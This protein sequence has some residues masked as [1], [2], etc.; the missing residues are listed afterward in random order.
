MSNYPNVEVHPSGKFIG[1]IGLEGVKIVSTG[2]TELFCKLKDLRS[3]N[4]RCCAFSP[5]GKYYA[6]VLSANHS[7]ELHL[8]RVDKLTTLRDTSVDLCKLFPNFKFTRMYNEHLQCKWSPDSELIA[9]CSNT[10]CLLLLDKNLEKVTDVVEDILPEDRFPSWSG[11]FDFA[12][13]SRHDLL[14]VGTSHGQLYVVSTESKRIVLET[15]TFTK[16]AIDCIKY[17]PQGTQI[18]VSTRDMCVYLI[19]SYTGYISFTIDIKSQ[20]TGIEDRL[21]SFPA[22]MSLDFST[23]GDYL[24]TGS[25]D[26]MIRLWKLF[27]P[28]ISLLRLCTMALLSYTA[29]SDVKDLPLPHQLRDLLLSFPK[30]K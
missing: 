14:A 15:E 10:F 12:P 19:D 6:I 23:K 16:E 20:C 8:S 21:E 7:F 25:C 4:Y 22:I 3:C 30:Y 26:G 24:V 1:Y 28:K 5:N 2:Q 18:A 17:N 11:T 29:P 13:C 27:A 9:V